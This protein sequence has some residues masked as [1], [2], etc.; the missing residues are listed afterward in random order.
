MAVGP[1]EKTR[2]KITALRVAK[3]GVWAALEGQVID[4][5]HHGLSNALDSKNLRIDDRD[6]IVQILRA[7]TRHQIRLRTFSRGHPTLKEA[8]ERALRFLE[9]VFDVYNPFTR[10]S[11]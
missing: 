8:D 6:R 11:A 4:K 10:D 5:L 9:K 1:N 7:I 2:N 3:P